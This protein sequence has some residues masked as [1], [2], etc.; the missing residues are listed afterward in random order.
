MNKEN[1]IYRYELC[2]DEGADAEVKDDEKRPSPQPPSSRW[3]Q[4][5]GHYHC[6]KVMPATVKQDQ[7]QQ[8]D[9]LIGGQVFDNDETGYNERENE[10]GRPN[11]VPAFPKV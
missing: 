8:P 3:S 5:F 7:H 6:P 1:L 2:P 9:T 10:N 11:P 4:S